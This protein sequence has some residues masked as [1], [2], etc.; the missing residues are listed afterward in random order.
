MSPRL[1]TFDLSS[2]RVTPLMVARSHQKFLACILS[3]QQPQLKESF[4]QFPKMSP[5]GWISWDWL[6]YLPNSKSVTI[7]SSGWS[8]WP[9]LGACQL[10]E[11][12]T[13]GPS[14]PHELRIGEAVPKESMASSAKR[15]KNVCWA[16]QSNEFVLKKCSSSPEHPAA[17]QNT[18]LNNIPDTPSEFQSTQFSLFH[19]IIVW[20]PGQLLS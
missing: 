20:Y 1:I 14:V 10:Q 2:S 8:D 7:T 3:S 18:T 17:Y 6:S 9:H 16:G 11:P 4:W 15:Q 12:S 19:C 5:K 13:L